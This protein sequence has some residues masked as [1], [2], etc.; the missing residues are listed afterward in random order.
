MRIEEKNANKMKQQ[1]KFSSPISSIFVH[2]RMIL[3]EKLKNELTK[4]SSA[5]KNGRKQFFYIK[6]QKGDIN[7]I[8]FLI[9]FIILIF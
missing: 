4:I 2:L 7:F 5:F 8:Q 1:I 6:I 3:Y 9:F